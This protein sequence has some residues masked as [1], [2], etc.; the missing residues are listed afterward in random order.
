MT[1]PM[2]E[3]EAREMARERCERR[4][5]ST[6]ITPETTARLI[7]A[8]ASDKAARLKT[9][10]KATVVIC[11]TPEWLR[12]EEV[13]AVFGIPKH[14]LIGLAVNGKVAARKTDPTL[15]ASA[16]IFEAESIRRAIGKM[17]PYAEWA[18]ARPDITNQTTP[19]KGK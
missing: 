17:T 7:E 9:L 14:T 3:K 13:N 2:T 8:I 6:G 19:R 5:F 15:K 11:T 16:V 12:A 1:G 4:P 18:R 10:A